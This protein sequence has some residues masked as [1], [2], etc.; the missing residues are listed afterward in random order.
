MSTLREKVEAA[1]A[2]TIEI[3]E[4]ARPVW[5]DVQP[6]GKVISEM[7]PNTIFVA[8]PPQ[9][10]W[11][12]VVPPVRVAIC[13]AAVHEKLAK[14]MDEAWEKVKAG[15]IEV[16]PAQDYALSCGAAQAVSYSMP[17]NV[18]KDSVYGGMGFCAPHPGASGHVLRWGIYDEEVEKGLCWLRDV[19]GPAQSEILKK[20][21]GMDIISVLTKTAG[22]GDENHCREFASSMYAELK[23]ID[24][25]MDLDLPDKAHF[26]QE[27]AE[28]ERFF[29]HVLMAGSCSVLASA[30][31]IPYSTIMTGMGGNGVEFGLKF[32]GTG[33]EWFTCPAP[34]ILG[35]FLNPEWT[36]KD[37]VGYLGDSCVTEVYGLGGLSAIAGPGYIRLEGAT[38]DEAHRRTDNARAVCLGEHKFAPVP[39]DDFKGTPCGVDMRKV[40]ALNIVPTSHGGSTRVVG[41]QGGA[42]SCPFPMEPFKKGLEAFSKKYREE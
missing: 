41:G 13:G 8:G 22:M 25:A 10:A 31:N 4:N 29:L 19:N 20:M 24:V 30:R 5:I 16:K 7:H 27:L 34:A 3:F 33:D 15:E 23:M 32:S 17:V 2:K 39:W 38:L 21:G 40:V 1:N 28:N 6:A 9:P 12:K 11:D 14:D 18:G 35:R 26:I 37:I 42:G 36:V